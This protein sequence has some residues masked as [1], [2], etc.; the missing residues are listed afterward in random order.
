LT[1]AYGEN[2]IQFRESNLSFPAR[3][4]EQGPGPRS[5]VPTSDLA[6]EGDRSPSTRWR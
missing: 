6:P 5:R 2:R 4:E 3:C 1:S